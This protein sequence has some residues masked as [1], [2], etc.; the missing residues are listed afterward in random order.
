MHSNSGVFTQPRRRHNEKILENKARVEDD[1]ELCT[2]F[3]RGDM[4]AFESLV[5]KHHQKVFHLVRGILGDWHQS[6]DVCQEVFTILY[7]RI[8]SF[9]HDSQ[10]STWIYRVAVNA[11]IKARRRG[12]GAQLDGLRHEDFPAPGRLCDTQSNEGAAFESEEV[13]Q[14]LLAPLPEKLRAAVLLR[15]QGGLSYEEIAHVLGCT[16]GAVEQRLH[17]A[18]VSLREIWKDRDDWFER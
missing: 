4:G 18:M 9:R 6:E 15:E 8:E 12:R 7:R 14:K 2:R 1:R 10:L 5:H 17:R 11:A 13:L 16:R 3:L